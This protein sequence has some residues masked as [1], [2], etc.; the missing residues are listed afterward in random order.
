MH[1][2]QLRRATAGTVTALLAAITLAACSSDEASSGA[3]HNEADVAFASDM[4]VHHAQALDMAQMVDGKEVSSEVEELAAEIEAAQAPEIEQMSGWLE[5]W[6]EDVPDPAAMD[7]SGM[8][9]GSGDMGMDMEM[10]GMM[11]A[12]D[13][14]ALETAEG[15]QFEQLWLSMMVEHHQGAIEM[16]ETEQDQGEFDPAVDLAGEIADAQAEEIERMQALLEQL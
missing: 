2:T 13:M 14:A 16:A 9:M 11:T 15:A 1:T 10:P 3:D 5:Q 8:D 12:E 7:H 4:I 6:G